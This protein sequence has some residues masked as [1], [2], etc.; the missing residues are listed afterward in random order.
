[1]LTSGTI[2]WAAPWDMEADGYVR[3]TV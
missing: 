2:Q 1:M 3:E